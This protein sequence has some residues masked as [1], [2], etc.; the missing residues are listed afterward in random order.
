LIGWRQHYAPSCSWTAGAGGVVDAASPGG[1]AV[2]SRGLCACSAAR[3]WPAASSRDE[4]KRKSP[5]TSSCL[6]LGTTCSGLVTELVDAALGARVRSTAGARRGK[7]SSAAFRGCSTLLVLSRVALCG[8]LRRVGGLS[9]VVQPS[10]H[11]SRSGRPR[12]S[13]GPLVLVETYSVIPAGPER[14][15]CVRQ[16]EGVAAV[17]AHRYG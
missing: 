13:I 4:L 9:E 15:R 16:N 12:S 6:L 10:A 1:A 7:F 2:R 3:N 5:P 11:W 8:G 17:S 14:T